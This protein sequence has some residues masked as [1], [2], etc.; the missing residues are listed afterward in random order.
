MA[1]AIIFPLLFGPTINFRMMTPKISVC[2]ASYNGAS[3]IA[4]QLQSILKQLDTNDELIIHDDGSKDNTCQIIKSF[5]DHRIILMESKVQRG[6]IKSFEKVLQQAKGEYIFMSDQDDVWMENKILTFMNQLED[7]DVVQSDATVVD[8]NLKTL[9]PSFFQLR[10]VK[11]GF[12]QNLWK[13]HY[14]GCNMAFRRKVLKIALPFPPSI[15]M[16]DLWIGL[17][18]EMFFKT[19][20]ISEK[21]LLYRRHSSNASQSTST[22][23]FSM[24]QKM[25]FRLNTIRFLPLLFFRNFKA[26]N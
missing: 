8:E 12:F 17:I 24:W 3:F 9:S 4:E 7:Y 1:A 25:K 6:V 5:N 10:K 16:H 15:P 19:C 13:N 11:Q 18:G 21:T 22:S 14:T 23:R 20:F 26:A 2:L